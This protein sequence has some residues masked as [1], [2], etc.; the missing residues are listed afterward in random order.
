MSNGT[1]DEA[2]FQAMKRRNNDQLVNDVIQ[3]SWSTSPSK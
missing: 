3:Y 1:A 2:E